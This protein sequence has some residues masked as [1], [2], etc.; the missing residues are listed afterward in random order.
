[1]IHFKCLKTLSWPMVLF[2]NVHS[3]LSWLSCCSKIHLLVVNYK[4]F[5]S[6]YICFFSCTVSYESQ[7]DLSKFQFYHEASRLQIKFVNRHS[8]LTLIECSYE[9]VTVQF[10]L[11]IK[12]YNM[13]HRCLDIIP[14]LDIILRCH[15]IETAS[16]LNFKEC[17]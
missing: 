1:M 17:C 8:E 3:L 11:K 9:F 15:R 13:K 10:I 4:K 6:L 14:S 12:F 16:C 7:H 2:L 5:C